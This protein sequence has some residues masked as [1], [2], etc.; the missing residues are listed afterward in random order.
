MNRLQ[1]C[2]DTGEKTRVRLPQFRRLTILDHPWPVRS[3][4]GARMSSRWGFSLLL[5]FLANHS[6]RQTTLQVVL[7]RLEDELLSQLSAADPATILDNLPL[8]E[9][10]SMT[11][12]RKMMQ[13]V[14]I[15]QWWGC[16]SVL[17]AQELEFKMS[18]RVQATRSHLLFDERSHSFHLAG[19]Q[20]LEKTKETS[21]EI[22]LQVAEAEKTEAVRDRHSR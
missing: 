13:H 9:A 18:L 21:R 22:A 1:N 7:S 19:C 16:F 6:F 15:S 10:K 2:A 5:G 8:I 4:S 14:M 17:L 20:G 12:W 3:W 11:K